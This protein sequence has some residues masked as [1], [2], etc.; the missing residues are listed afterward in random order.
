MASLSVYNKSET[1]PSRGRE[2]YDNE[3]YIECITWKILVPI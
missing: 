1:L 3:Y 2:N